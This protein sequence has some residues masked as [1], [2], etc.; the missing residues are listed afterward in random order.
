MSSPARERILVIKLGAL[1]DILLAEGAMADIRRA[2]PHAELHVLTRQPYAALLERCPWVDAVHVDA[3]APRWDLVAMLHWRQWFLQQAFTLVYDLQN[4]RRTHFYRRMVNRRMRT[5]PPWSYSPQW[6]SRRQATMAV[7]DQ[8]ARQL[9]D[10]G[11]QPAHCYRPHPAWLSDLAD[12][13]LAHVP[14]LQTGFVLLLPGASA[15]HAHKRWPHYRALSHALAQRGIDVITVPGP[16]EAD[17][18]PGYAGTVLRM[19][20]RCLSLPEV[21]LVARRALCT[22]GN[23]SGP[24]HLAACLDLPC[25]ALFD[26]RSPGLHRTGITARPFATRLT[27]QPLAALALPTVLEAVL[28]K[29][30]PH[31]VRASALASMPFA[32]HAAVERRA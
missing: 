19:P 10:A 11:I 13:G 17:L 25:V 7:P 31:A 29:V 28:D 3:N 16:D 14:A 18:G 6:R 27:G 12:A 2:H 20:D 15:R 24:L 23:D 22:V 21:S 9:L 4:S 8:H 5:A 26:A 32:S 1:G 30:Q